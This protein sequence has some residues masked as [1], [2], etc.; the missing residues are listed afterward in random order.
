MGSNSRNT[1]GAE[2]ALL[3]TLQGFSLIY[4]KC[5]MYG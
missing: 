3:M 4:S 2:F 5:Y 1:E